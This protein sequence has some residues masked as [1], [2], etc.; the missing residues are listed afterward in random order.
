M[1]KISLTDAHHLAAITGILWAIFGMLSTPITKLFNLDSRPALDIIP[2]FVNENK[3]CVDFNCII[4]LKIA[5]IIVAALKYIL[6]KLRSEFNV[7]ASRP[8]FNENY[9]GK[10]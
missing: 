1:I 3:I 4:T 9:N 8:R 2:S 10:H 5:H 6:T 7:R